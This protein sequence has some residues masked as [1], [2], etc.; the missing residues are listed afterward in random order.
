ME[1]TVDK[2]KKVKVLAE[3]GGHPIAGVLGTLS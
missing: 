1:L 3:L 2:S